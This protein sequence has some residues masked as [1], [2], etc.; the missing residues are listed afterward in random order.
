MSDKLLDFGG[1][2]AIVTGAGRG[3]GRAHAVM[4]ASRGCRVVVNDLAGDDDPAGE[5]VA[6]IVAAGGTATADHHSVIDEPAGIVDTARQQFGQLDIVVNNAGVLEGSTLADTD[7]ELWHRVF[8][9]HFRG[10]VDVCRA[11]WPHLVSSGHGRII[12]TSSSGMLGNSGLTSYGA[13]KAAVFGFTRSLAIEGLPL[14]IGVNCILPSARTRI[15]DM[16]EDAD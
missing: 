15:T 9:I 4:L 14:G 12:N 1:A 10:T 7:P 8:D 3:L 11:A 16:I 6:E 5:V 13:A 2:V